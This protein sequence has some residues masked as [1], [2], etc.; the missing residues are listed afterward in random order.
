MKK[1]EWKI[2]VAAQILAAQVS[3]KDN[4][5]FVERRNGYDHFRKD[6]AHNTAIY[7]VN[8]L[9]TEDEEEDK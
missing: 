9:W 2:K 5:P 8:D 1:H 4:C 6:L 7:L 3:S